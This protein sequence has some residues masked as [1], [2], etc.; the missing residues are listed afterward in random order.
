MA[1]FHYM[2]AKTLK[3]ACDCSVLVHPYYT[4][5]PLLVYQQMCKHWK[6]TSFHSTGATLCVA[7]LTVHFLYSGLLRKSEE[8]TATFIQI[9]Y[10]FL[11]DSFLPLQVIIARNVTWG[12]KEFNAQ[13]LFFVKVGVRLCLHR[14]YFP[15]RSTS[16]MV[17]LDGTMK[18]TAHPYK[19]MTI[20][21]Q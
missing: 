14:L 4:I 12:K 5:R 1:S 13:M 3:S 6:S 21:S 19:E 15:G 9:L 11:F 8:K 20:V 10:T 17:H 7:L 16:I 2:N 18:C